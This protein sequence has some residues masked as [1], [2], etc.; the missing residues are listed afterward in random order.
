MLKSHTAT[1]SHNGV[2]RNN[3]QHLTGSRVLYRAR[4]RECAPALIPQGARV[5]N[6][7]MDSE[8]AEA[9]MDTDGNI[10]VTVLLD[11]E[12]YVLYVVASTTGTGTTPEDY[13][14][15]AAFDFGTPRESSAEIVGVSGSNFI[16]S[17]STH[18][19]EF[20]DD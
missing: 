2:I 5:L 20:L 11:K 3:T 15:S 19:R 16:I 12:T 17:Y 7:P 14:H 9:L 18:V 6:L 1:A 13:A 10:T 8:R 4:I